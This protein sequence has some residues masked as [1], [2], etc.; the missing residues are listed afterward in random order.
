V[1]QK[2]ARSLDPE[3]MHELAQDKEQG[4]SKVFSSARLEM[5]FTKIPD[6]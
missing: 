4:T 2:T 5:K 6:K 3:L 1:T